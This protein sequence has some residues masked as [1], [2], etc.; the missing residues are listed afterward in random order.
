MADDL[1]KRWDEYVESMGC[2]MG[3]AEHM[4]QQMRDRL[5]ELEAKL[6][7]AVVA[8]TDIDTLDPEGFV[9]GC[10]QSALAGLVLRMGETARTTIAELNGRGDE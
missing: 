4:A 6:A 3:E 1:V 9:H 7:R 5:E 2:V 10:S 8:L